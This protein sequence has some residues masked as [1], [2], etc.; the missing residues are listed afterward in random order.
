M[1]VF[2]SLISTST[3]ATNF[4][5]SMKCEDCGKTMWAGETC[6][7]GFKPDPKYIEQ[8]FR[9]CEECKNRGERAGA[10]QENGKNKH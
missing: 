4:V 5:Y 10:Y 1:R 7:F 2:R 9:I 8:S 6:W 3:N